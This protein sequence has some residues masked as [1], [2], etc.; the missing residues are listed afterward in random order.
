MDRLVVS[1]SSVHVV[2]AEWS[3]HPT[4]GRPL[5]GHAR[6]R[7]YLVVALGVE[8]VVVLA[9]L[10][11]TVDVAAVLTAGE[12][13]DGGRFRPCC[14]PVPGKTLQGPCPSSREGSMPTPQRRAP[15]PVQGKG[16][17]VGAEVV[18]LGD[19]VEA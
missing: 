12:P 1:P 3:T 8:A 9:V 7:P 13:A 18:C 19:E 16:G 4:S 15:G 10:V 6:E 2:E 11:G 5:G 14:V 17:C